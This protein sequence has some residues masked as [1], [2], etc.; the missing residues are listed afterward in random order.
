MCI[1]WATAPWLSKHIF[2]RIK[3][4][5]GFPYADA[6]CTRNE[7]SFSL[8][9]DHSLFVR[10]ELNVLEMRVTF[11]NKRSKLFRK[12]MNITF[13]FKRV[14]AASRKENEAFSGGVEPN[15]SLQHLCIWAFEMSYRA[16]LRL[17]SGSRG[18]AKLDDERQLS[19]I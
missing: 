19:P 17:T 16:F 10:M 11:P 6:L 13:R 9:N 5:F 7:Q 8:R 1:N 18:S 3:N 15:N 4:C 12:E 2:S 14:T